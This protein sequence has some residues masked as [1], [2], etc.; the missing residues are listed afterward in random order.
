MSFIEKIKEVFGGVGGEDPA[1]PSSVYHV[2]DLSGFAGGNGNRDRLSPRD[3]VGLLQRVASF[4][5]KEQLQAH[6]II[7]GRPLRE[8]PEDSVFK[9]VQV[10]Y[11]EQSE[12]IADKALALAGR[13]RSA[14]IVTQNRELE[15]QAQER[16]IPTLRAS[17]FRR[18]MEDNAGRG[19]DGGRSAG[20]RGRRRTRSR[21][22]GGG[23]GGNASN[24]GNRTGN[25]Q[26][27]KKA[28][29][30]TKPKEQPAAKDGVS[31]L[32]DLV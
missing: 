29:A 26:A 17:S 8:A 12:A 23:G 32:I 15:T 6:V 3:R 7:E 19:G 16:G 10:S 4:V 30:E 21:R 14:L 9:T 13:E 5:E 11:V 20:G 18:G 27:D 25:G 31:D 2:I 24:G 28:N 1:G 22:G